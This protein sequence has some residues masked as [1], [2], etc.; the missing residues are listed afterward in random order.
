MNTPDTTFDVV[1]VGAGISGAYTAYRLQQ[2]QLGAE[3]PKR[4]ALFN[5]DDRIGGRLFTRT[6]PGMPHVHA[7]LG[8]MRFIPG[9][10]YLT[11]GLIGELELPVR[12][13]PVGNADPAM[14]GNAN[15]LY[16]RSRHLLFGDLSESGE[17]ACCGA[18]D[19]VRAGED[20]ATLSDELRHE[21]PR[22][23]C[24]NATSTSGSTWRVFIGKPLY[25]YGLWELLYLVLSSEGYRFRA[26][27]GR[28][29]LECRERQ[30]C[31]DASA[32]S[33]RKR[34]LSTL[35]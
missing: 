13:L 33:R 10:Q 32:A 31:R 21:L 22:S 26:G 9:N 8:G 19:A 35:R 3:R 6:L 7:E 11:T 25:H 14:G 18:P 24:R 17:G 2:R 15:Y 12:D 1:V 23:Q 28:L 27:C 5:L 30:C 34:E 20:A 16:L 4:I 29:R